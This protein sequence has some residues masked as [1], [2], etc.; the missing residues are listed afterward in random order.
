[1]PYYRWRGITLNARYC[2]GRLFARNIDELERVLLRQDIALVTIKKDRLSIPLP[3]THV[4]IIEV[5]R[6]LAVLLKSGILLPQAVQTVAEQLSHCRLRRIFLDIAEHV[7][8]GIA[9]SK[10]MQGYPSLFS[11]VMVHMVRSGEA[12]GCIANA[13]EALVGYLE[14][15]QL[16]RKKMHR[17]LIIPVITLCA[18]FAISLGVMLGIVPRF[19]SFFHSMGKPLPTIT[20][21]LIFVSNQMHK[22]LV[23]L[24]MMSI[25]GFVLLAYKA[26]KAR[27]SMA[28]SF[29]I[30]R[31]P[32]IGSLIMQSALLY[33]LHA[34]SMLIKN[35]VPL[36]A[37][38]KIVQPLV[39]NEYIRDCLAAIVDDV[40]AG[41][42]LRTAMVS[43]QSQPFHPE[44]LALMQVGQD[45]GTL[46]AMVEKAAYIY[47]QK[48]ES[49][50]LF[51]TFIIQPLLLLFLGALVAFLVFALY[52]PIF[53][54]A[55]VV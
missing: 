31:L 2:N 46:G 30:T 1:M 24:V 6:Q 10:A 50:L 29:Y 22:P 54:L 36:V 12:S 27:F 40:A 4:Q 21:Q 33:W 17:A 55:Q 45:A 11:T 38:L 20:Q 41:N 51:C 34:L 7:V 14:M 13:L 39:H 37:A 48:V 8:H 18:F 16:F 23:W 26:C 44:V 49:V 5:F 28:Y 15:V 52:M 3:I 19:A 25:I 32:V 43:A 47:Q 42:S 9:C 35:G 53:N